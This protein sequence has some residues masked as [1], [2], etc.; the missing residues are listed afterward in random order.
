[1]PF[2]KGNQ[3]GKQNLGKRKESKKT[4]WLMESL[5]EHGFDYEAV[6]VKFLNLA[7]KGDRHALEM[8]HLLVKLVPHIANAPKQ[9]TGINQ[10]E[11]LVINRFDAPAARAAVID[12]TATEAESAGLDS[13]VNNPAGDIA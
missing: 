12:T 13:S 4:I 11:T 6:L 3:L 7:S 9:D 8:A 2:K 5:Q 10:I 1:M